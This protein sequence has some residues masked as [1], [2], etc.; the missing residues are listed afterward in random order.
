MNKRLSLTS[1][2]VF[3]C[4]S[5]RPDELIDGSKKKSR[6]EDATTQIDCDI[7]FASLKDGAII[8][9][10]R[11]GFKKRKHRRLGRLVLPNCKGD[12][13]LGPVSSSFFTVFLSIL[14]GA[15]NDLRELFQ[16]RNKSFLIIYIF[17]NTFEFHIINSNQKPIH[18]FPKS[19]F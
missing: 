17:L 15:L 3:K 7:D 16:P 19:Y 14:N 9:Y 11:P 8:V 10:Y 5:T 12:G 1:P 2:R 18:R 6:K 4:H 13:F